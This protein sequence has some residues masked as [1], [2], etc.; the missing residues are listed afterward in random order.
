MRRLVI[1]LLSIALALVAGRAAHAGAPTDQLK[2]GV[3]RVLAILQDP[4]L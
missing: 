4:A 2:A 1:P 3:D